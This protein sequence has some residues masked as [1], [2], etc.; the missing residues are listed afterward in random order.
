M[1]KVLHRHKLLLLK[2]K[3]DILQRFDC[4]ESINSFGDDCSTCQFY[5][6]QDYSGRLW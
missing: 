2:K 3:K 1:S 6:Q 4:P 5:L